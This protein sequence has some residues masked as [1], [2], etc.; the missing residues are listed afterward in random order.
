[1]SGDNEMIGEFLAENVLATLE[2]ELLAFL[3]ATSITER[4]CGELASVLA[5]IR[6]GQDALEDV[7]RRGLFLRRIDDDPQWF[8]YHQMF[9]GYLRRRL[10]RDEPESPQRP[11]PHRI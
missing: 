7:E 9:A 10:E 5:G 8:R 3:S 4:I 11:A 2:P 6:G 1:M